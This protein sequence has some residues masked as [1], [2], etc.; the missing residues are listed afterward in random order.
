M[1]GYSRRWSHL[2]ARSNRVGG[3]FALPSE[4]DSL[5]SAYTQAFEFT[6]TPLLSNQFVTLSP[7][8]V[9][10]DMFAY[11]NQPMFKIQI[12]SRVTG[13]RPIPYDVHPNT[14]GF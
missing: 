12:A 1:L 11:F 5:F 2:I 8:N 14:F 13:R 9:R 7:E 10:R 4:T 6:E 3:L